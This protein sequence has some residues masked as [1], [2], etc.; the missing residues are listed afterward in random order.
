M[1][2]RHR[3]WETGLSE[4]KGSLGVRAR[5]GRC[6]SAQLSQGP[7]FAEADRVLGPPALGTPSL[8]AL[9]Q[10]RPQA[11]THVCA[12]PI[13]S[14]HDHLLGRCFLSMALLCGRLPPLP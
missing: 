7:S 11:C 2:R 5:G 14:A 12:S 9:G 1:G 3:L 13:L 10:G 6:L 4:E 8:G